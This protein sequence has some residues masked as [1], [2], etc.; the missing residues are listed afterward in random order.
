MS[1]DFVC[2]VRF[3][4]SRVHAVA[5]VGPVRCDVIDGLVVETDVEQLG[6]LSEDN[7]TRQVLV[8]EM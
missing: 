2:G 7:P 3:D 4:V 1:V 8:R 5:A 6:L